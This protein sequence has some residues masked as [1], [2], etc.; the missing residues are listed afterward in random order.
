[1]AKPWVG[2]GGDG[3]DGPCSG[4]RVRLRLRGAKLHVT[5]NCPYFTPTGDPAFDQLF[6]VAAMPQPGALDRVLTPEVR[7]R[8][9]AHDD[10]VFQPGRY[11]LGCVSRGAFPSAAAVG[12]RISEVLGIV[13]AFP[14]SA[15]PA[16]VDHSADDLAAR[17]AGLTSMEE[18]MAF[19]VA[20]TP[21]DRE[22]LARSGS[23]L[24]PLADV[25]TPQ[26]AMA[27]FKSLDQQQKMQLMT[28]FMQVK[29]DQRRR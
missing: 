3:G 17:I 24:A 12:Q 18:G 14:A 6:A 20:L 19:L 22:R 15:G 28:M 29:H 13:A 1:M 9:M 21:A 11:L 4:F 25:R 16:H 26:E 27:R 5:C 2:D 10:W 8:I 23:P 7:Q